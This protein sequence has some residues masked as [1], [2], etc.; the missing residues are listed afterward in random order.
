MSSSTSQFPTW[1]DIWITRAI[2]LLAVV[3]IYRLVSQ[4]LAMRNSNPS[5]SFMDAVAASLARH[6]KAAST[7][8]L[9]WHAPNATEI[10]DLSRVIGGSGVYG[11]IFNSSSTSPNDYGVYNWCNMPHVRAT[12]YKQPSSEYQLQYVEVVRR[13]WDAAAVRC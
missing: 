7:V 8:D 2:P 9:R 13:D 3:L 11:F 6:G 4:E 12:E 10:N 1:G 5:T